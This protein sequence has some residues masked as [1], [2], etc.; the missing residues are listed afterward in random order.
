MVYVEYI[1]LCTCF[2]NLYSLNGKLVN[3]FNRTF[4][5]QQVYAWSPK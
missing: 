5:R 4:V 1:K 2:E 3:G